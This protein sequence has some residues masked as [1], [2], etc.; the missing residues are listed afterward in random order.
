MKATTGVPDAGAAVYDVTS[1]SRRTKILI[2]D[3]NRNNLLALETTLE[4]LGQEII[5]ANSG[6]EAL[7]RLLEDDFAVILMDVQMPGMDGFETASLIRQ[8]ERSKATPIIFITASERSELQIFAG[9]S[10]GAVDYLCKPIVPEILRSKVSVFIDLHIRMENIREQEKLIRQRERDDH[11]KRMIQERQTFELSRLRYQAE[12]DK[13]IAELLSKRAQELEQENQRQN[14]FLA[15]LSHE[16]RNPLAPILHALK[17]LRVSPSK[18]KRERSLT[19]LEHQ[20]NHLTSL[21][22]D[23]LDVT[24]IRSGKINLSREPLELVPLLSRVVE[25][26]RP[27]LMEKKQSIALT[28]QVE[29][30]WCTADRVR[31]E[32]VLLNLI[33]NAS[34][35]SNEGTNV[36]V[37]LGELE[38]RVTIKVKDQGIGIEPDFLPVMFNLFSQASS[39]MSRAEGG[40][41]VGLALAHRLVELQNG[42][43][44]AESEGKGKGA[45]FTISLPKTAPLENTEQP[46]REQHQMKA[47]GKRVLVVDDN[48]IAT[49]AINMVLED[50]GH[51]IKTAHDGAG[52]IGAAQDFDP[53]VVILDIGLPD[54]DGYEVARRLRSSLSSSYF[55]ALT[56][57]GQESDKARAREAGFDHHLVK[58]VDPEEIER[59]LQA[60]PARA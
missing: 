3:D 50:E 51:D 28:V 24:R 57:Y 48:I 34:K 31:L 49:E 32:Q 52:A 10:L 41:G 2:V 1:L 23:L 46:L 13:Q 14:E 16:L 42:E 30:L 38:G 54:M 27:V 59:L 11:E 53:D 56:G 44:T 60:L 4:R 26:S 43:I 58:P 17:A 22:G 40:L 25:S 29:N 19:I 5:R 6:E 37:V 18:E 47:K 8:R 7:S 36:E 35:Y 45:V 9:Y 20:F 15:M 39:S 12:K 21:L 33:K 55:I